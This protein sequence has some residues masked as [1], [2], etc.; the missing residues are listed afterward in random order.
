MPEA[1]GEG[2]TGNVSLG[3][4]WISS[5]MLPGKSGPTDFTRR[6]YMSNKEVQNELC[7]SIKTRD[8]VYRVALSYERGDKY[9]KTYN[10]SGGVLVAAPAGS[11]Q[12]KTDPV[13]PARKWLSPTVRSNGVAESSEEEITAVAAERV[14]SVLLVI[15]AV[16][17]RIILLSVQHR[18][19]RLI[20]V[21][22]Q[23]TTNVRAEVSEQQE[24]EA[25][26]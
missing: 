5:Q 26:D 25:W 10:V 17:H 1:A 23:N 14:A 22:K 4:E 2:D 12:I 13:S 24:G 8:E 21:G 18:R 16:L 9:A 19:L 20:F 15:R 11:L 6:I 3:F 7:R